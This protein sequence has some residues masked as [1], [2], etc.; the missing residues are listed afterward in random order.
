MEWLLLLSILNRENQANKFHVYR[1]YHMIL[2]AWIFCLSIPRG[3]LLYF[4]MGFSFTYILTYN[5]LLGQCQRQTIFTVKVLLFKFEKNIFN[6]L[7]SVK[8]EKNCNL[9]NKF[10]QEPSSDVSIRCRDIIVKTSQVNGKLML[11]NLLQELQPEM[12]KPI[13]IYI[14]FNNF[15]PTCN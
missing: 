13:E 1:Y 10:I 2:F 14:R 7:Y 5:S 3:Y 11:L 4:E 12:F 15:N 9:A 8:F 6:Q